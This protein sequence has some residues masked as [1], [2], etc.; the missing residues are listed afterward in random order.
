[1]TQHEQDATRAGPLS[2]C[3]PEIQALIHQEYQDDLTRLRSGARLMAYVAASNATE[4]WEVV[5]PGA[6]ATQV[7]VRLIDMVPETGGM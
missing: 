1:M 3:P 6:T 2:E 7:M 4:T 5:A